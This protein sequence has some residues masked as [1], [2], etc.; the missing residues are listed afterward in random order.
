[1]RRARAACN[2]LPMSPG[3]PLIAVEPTRTRVVADSLRLA[4]ILTISTMLVIGHGPVWRT[5]VV[6]A[7]AYL[8][9]GV[10]AKLQYRPVR[11]SITSSAIAREDR[12]V[13]VEIP[14]AAITLVKWTSTL[15]AGDQLTILGS[16]ERLV[17]DITRRTEP[18]VNALGPLL[19]SLGRDRAVIAD[20]ITR[21]WVGLSEASA[22][23]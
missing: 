15:K 23:G 3:L 1:M 10:V 20:G 5:L 19:A 7:F 18:L 6:L 9:V 12:G 22:R 21:H 2:T 8:V 13:V 17:V 4:A 14:I 16:D 11:Y